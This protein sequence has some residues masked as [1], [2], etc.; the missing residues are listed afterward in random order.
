M[1][2]HTVTSKPHKEGDT[3]Y[4]DLKKGDWFWGWAP[5]GVPLLKIAGGC[6]SPVNGTVELDSGITNYF[7]GKKVWRCP[8]KTE[9]TIITGSE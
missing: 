8:P 6:L 9:I 2:D 7:V 4:S 5:E 1:A 3:L